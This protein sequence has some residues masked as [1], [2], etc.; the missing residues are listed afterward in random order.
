[1]A[2]QRASTGME[3][4][5]F[6]VLPAEKRFIHLSDMREAK[7]D[8]GHE[9]AWLSG[10]GTA[11]RERRARARGGEAHTSAI[12]LA[13]P[14]PTGTL[15]RDFSTLVAELLARGPAL[16]GLRAMQRLVQQGIEFAAA[17]P[18]HLLDTSSTLR[19]CMASHKS[20]WASPRFCGGAPGTTRLSWTTRAQRAG[21]SLCGAW[22][23]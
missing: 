10:C 18:E 8:A 23:R 3:W 15:G 21:C 1:M 4:K 11:A 7:T 16:L 5:A 22:C 6:P 14:F 2:G 12:P 13:Y 20:C 9:G 19:S 17:L